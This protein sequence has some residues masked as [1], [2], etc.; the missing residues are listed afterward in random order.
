MPNDLNASD[1]HDSTAEAIANAPL[2][3]PR[4]LRSRKSIPVQFVRF[5]AFNARMLRMV[6]KGHH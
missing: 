5:L 2:P 6:A 1:R 4:T 3:T